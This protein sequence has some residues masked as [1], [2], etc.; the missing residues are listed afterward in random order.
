MIEAPMNNNKW[1]GP[2]NNKSVDIS[3]DTSVGTSAGAGTDSLSEDNPAV[4]IERCNNGEDID[5]AVVDRAFST[6]RM[7]AEQPNEEQPAFQNLLGCCYQI[8]RVVEEDPQQAVYWY[9][10][11]AEAGFDQAQRNLGVCYF[12]G[13][14]VEKNLQTATHWYSKAADQ[15]NAIAQY[16]LGLAYFLG[17]GVSA[18]YAQA[19]RWIKV[20]A[21]QNL[22]DGQYWLGFCYAGGAGTAVDDGQAVYWLTK[23]ADNG[24]L[25]AQYALS[26]RYRNGSGVDKDPVKAF[27][28]CK[29]VAERLPEGDPDGVQSQ[30]DLGIA[31]AKGE[32][33]DVDLDQ[34]LMWLQKAQSNGYKDADKAIEVVKAARDG[35]TSASGNAPSTVDSGYDVPNGPVT[36]TAPVMSNT[37]ASAPASASTTLT[38]QSTGGDAKAQTGLPKVLL[39]VG[40]VLAVLWLLTMLFG[41]NSPLLLILAIAC[42]VVRYLLDKKKINLHK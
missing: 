38:A 37:Q 20:A 17:I 3:A 29:N 2:V 40:V 25:Q 41:S 34:A 9:R 13:Y 15:G 39:I 4:I 22:P 21:S 30:F 31:Y 10:K 24:Q 18:D 27:D 8:G 33:T 19:F 26:V 1:T 5:R 32:G 14:G 42:F 12:N 35:D 23:A 7:C 16:Q 36:P 11:S 28:L 6:I